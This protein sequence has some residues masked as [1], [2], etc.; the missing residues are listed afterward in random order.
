MSKQWFVRRGDKIRG[1][2]TSAEVKQLVS[3]GILREADMVRQSENSDWREAGTIKGLF[4]AERPNTLVPP[5]LPQITND[6]SSAS[7]TPQS[8]VSQ[9]AHESTMSMPSSSTKATEAIK[10]SVKHILGKAKQAKDFAALHARRAQIIQFSL[11]KAYLNLGKH[12]LATTQ[13]RE[14]FGDLYERLA[15]IDDRIAKITAT[16]AEHPA[17]TD[18]QSKLRTGAVQLHA[19][20]K[21]TQL[22]FQREA[23]IRELGQKAAEVNCLSADSSELVSAVHVALEEI[24]ELDNKNGSK[25]SGKTVPMWQRRSVAL[26]LTVFCFPLGLLLVG[27]NPRFSSRLKV[28]WIGGLAVLAAIL[29]FFAEPRTHDDRNGQANLTGPLP[30]DTQPKFATHDDRNGQANLTGASGISAEATDSGLPAEITEQKKWSELPLAKMARNSSHDAYGSNHVLFSPN[31][32]FV[33]V[34]EDSGN[35]LNLR[36]WN[37][38]TGEEHSAKGPD[39][40]YF[41]LP[42]AFS[43]NE[44]KLACL[45]GEFLRIWDL[46]TVP[47]TLIESLPLEDLEDHNWN[48]VS[49]GKEDTLVVSVR[50]THSVPTIHQ[51]LKIQASNISLDGPKRSSPGRSRENPSIDQSNM[52]ISP[53]GATLASAII[54]FESGQLVVKAT[55]YESGNQIR[56]I[57]IG[58]HEPFCERFPSTSLLAGIKAS[59]S[60]F[61][62]EGSYADFSPDG[63]FLLVAAGDKEPGIHVIPVTTWQGSVELE[64]GEF[65]TAEG[66]PFDR[67]RPR[68][69][70]SDGNLI[71][72][73]AILRSKTSRSEKAERVAIVHELATGKQTAKINL[74]DEFLRGTRDLMD[75]EAERIEQENVSFSSDGQS[76]VVA[77]SRDLGWNNEKQR[78]E[79]TWSVGS[80]RLADGKPDFLLSG[81][82]GGTAIT[83]SP[84]GEVLVLNG[85]ERVLD[86]KRLAKI[87]SDCD[88]GDRQ[89]DNSNHADALLSYCSVVHDEM[90]SL[91]CPNLDQVWSRCI[92]GFAERGETA[93][94]RGIIIHLQR[95]NIAVQPETDQGKRVVSELFAE[96]T[97]AIRLSRSEAK[98]T[99]ENRLSQIRKE[100][101]GKHVRS[102]TMSKR[103][104]VDKLSATASYGTINDSGANAM[105]DNFTFQDVFG[106][107]D[108]NVKFED[109]TRLYLYRCNDGAIQ[110]TISIRDSKAF[111][112]GI[113]QF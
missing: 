67:Y 72:G 22:H 34:I 111:L 7:S 18:L 19:K 62:T 56:E 23:L 1:P 84:N 113:N 82:T 112:S 102:G 13:C 103:E 16:A 71:A 95:N 99:E 59:R 4:D 81:F 12:V 77:V 43:P 57:I 70:S 50:S 60:F 14:Q 9:T 93:K 36:L 90:A 66:K 86:I 100:N 73:I 38:T 91:V 106:D 63:R 37:T 78:A 20:G 21:T 3:K 33:A 68:C 31:S 47:S 52:A 39:S 17:A 10:A 49:W 98:E 51:R 44:T 5:P 45:D 30:P 101:Q 92:D 58:L 35:K 108:S 104:F 76:L 46:K 32:G 8:A 61:D 94:S 28:T 27:L 65:S 80:W 83:L 85:G 24:A 29:L 109:I 26:L 11:P 54:E 87:R 42:A 25:N 110:L 41:S 105:F 6:V 48:S 55:E 74:G 40:D 15:T 53:D 107:P 97:D 89:W 96:Q 69:F 75:L 88:E 64:P 79:L 2:L